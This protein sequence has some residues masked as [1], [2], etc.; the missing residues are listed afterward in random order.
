MEE[1][2]KSLARKPSRVYACACAHTHPHTDTH[3]VL[4]GRK[5]CIA[6]KRDSRY[7]RMKTGCSEWSGFSHIYKYPIIHAII[8]K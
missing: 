4:H 7:V 1:T 2:I 6:E 8:F 5:K 3:R